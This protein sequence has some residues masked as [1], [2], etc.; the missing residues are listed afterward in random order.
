M[1]LSL[2][3]EPPPKKLSSKALKSVRDYLGGADMADEQQGL[4]AC[5]NA[6]GSVLATPRF[7]C[8]RNDIASI[9][10]KLAHGQVARITD[11]ELQSLRHVGSPA[12]GRAIEAARKELKL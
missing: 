9:E 8:Y 5:F 7:Q 2:F 10:A 12:L 11:Q 1:Q 4:N 6:L 3:G